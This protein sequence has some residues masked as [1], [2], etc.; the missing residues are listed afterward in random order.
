MPDPNE[1]VPG[2]ELVPVNPPVDRLDLGLGETAMEVAAAPPPIE[3][4]SD[5]F[6]LLPE[7]ESSTAM[8]A[9]IEADRFRKAMADQHAIS[10]R[11]IREAAEAERRRAA[12]AEE[13]IRARLMLERVRRELSDERHL[14]RKENDADQRRAGALRV[15]I[16]EVRQSTEHVR[17]KRRRELRFVRG[18]AVGLL[19]LVLALCGL[20]QLRY[21]ILRQSAEDVSP[22][23]VKQ[24]AT[25][26]P[27]EMVAAPA[28][29]SGLE[30][31]DR[32]LAPYEPAS[33]ETA[34]HEANRWLKSQ[35]KNPCTIRPGGIEAV[36][37]SRGSPNPLKKALDNCATAV[38]QLP[39]RHSEK[40]GN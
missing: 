6:A 12:A 9:A 38:D 8:E 11:A 3:A 22:V 15:S 16:D 39:A 23:L 29:L 37:V 32:A 21:W 40:N 35:G 24:K 31:L 4:P 25:P 28:N 14:R 17:Q 26:S 30:H 36:V 27:G 5:P 1:T 18:A 20:R 10:L 34:L 13:A 2:Q 7:Q 19:V 33:T